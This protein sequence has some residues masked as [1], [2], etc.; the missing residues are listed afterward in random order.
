MAGR[1]R[2]FWIGEDILPT[3][4]RS[5]DRLIKPPLSCTGLQ[6]LAG[7]GCGLKNG[8]L[9]AQLGLGPTSS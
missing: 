5:S 7:L 3:Q 8:Y 4:N 9:D 2:E 6:T 1:V